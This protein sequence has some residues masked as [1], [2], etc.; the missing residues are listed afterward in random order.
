MYAYFL[1][2][3]FGA[4]YLNPTQYLHAG[5]KYVKLEKEAVSMDSINMVGYDTSLVDTYI[6]VFNILEFVFYTGWLQVRDR[7][8]QNLREAFTKKIR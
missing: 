4:Q 2:S 7:P 8:I 5:N 1:A 3:L 6:P